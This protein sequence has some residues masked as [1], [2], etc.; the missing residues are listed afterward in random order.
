MTG[1]DYNPDY[2]TNGNETPSGELPTT[3]MLVETRPVEPDG[4]PGGDVGPLYGNPLSHLFEDLSS[5]FPHSDDHGGGYPPFYARPPVREMVPSSF[6]LTTKS[7]LAPTTAG[8]VVSQLGAPWVKNL[9]RS[10]V[11]VSTAAKRKRPSRE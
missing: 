3:L 7:L 4:G 2:D 5:W 8:L 1:Y 10:F 6:R 11:R 9:R